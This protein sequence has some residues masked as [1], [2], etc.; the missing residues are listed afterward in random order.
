MTPL[1]TMSAKKKKVGARRVV[2]TMRGSSTTAPVRAVKKATGSKK[3]KTTQ[4]ASLTSKASRGKAAAGQ[5]APTQ[6]TAAQRTA[7]Q[8]AAPQLLLERLQAAIPDPHVELHFRD[9][10]QLMVAV[11]LSAQSTDR[12]VNLVTPEV[13]R[14]WPTPAA[15][16][17]AAQEEVELVVKSTGFFRNKAKAIRGASRMLIE[18]FA[19][20]VPRTLEELVEVPGVARKTA[21]VVLGAAYGVS[22]GIV[23]D[24]HAM[25]V[26]QRLAL[27]REETPEKIE[28]DLCRVFE[29]KH[30]IALSHQ[31]VLHGRHL[32]IARAPACT[33]CALNELCPARQ[34]PPEGSWPERA[35]GEASDMTERSL[36]FVRALAQRTY[37]ANTSSGNTSSVSSSAAGIA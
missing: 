23:T 5:R 25:R 14:R 22:S 34:A 28:A 9:P 37:E 2:T 6:R 21:N 24:T 15:L 7:A 12:T 31:L 27:T 4:K 17:D 3:A 18:R 35:Q 30:W 19:G 29:P 11:I 16:A 33:R 1:V 26:S 36:G 13:F 10:W 8:H 20:S 32:C